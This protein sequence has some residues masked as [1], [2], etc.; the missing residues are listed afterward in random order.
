MRPTESPEP[1]RSNTP[2]TWPMLARFNFA[3]GNN[4]AISSFCALTRA[5][6]C[7]GRWL[8]SSVINALRWPP[9]RP[10]SSGSS[11][12]TALRN[13]RCVRKFSRGRAAARRIVL[14]RSLTSASR[15]FQRSVLKGRSGSTRMRAGVAAGGG[16]ALVPVVFLLSASEPL[17]VGT[18]AA[19]WRAALTLPGRAPI[20]GPRSSM[21]STLEVKSATSIGRCPPSDTLSDP[22]MSLSPKRPLKS[23]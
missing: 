16:R 13:S 15:L 23:W 14:A 10:K 4:L 19:A 12:T 17:S 6:A 2:L 9:A 20:N 1:L 21:S 22:A 18:P 11:V 3:V 5:R 8:P 7:I